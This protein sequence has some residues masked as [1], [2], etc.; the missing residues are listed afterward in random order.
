M[1][2][3]IYLLLTAIMLF[4]A[5]AAFGQSPP[6]STSSQ[7]VFQPASQQ[8]AMD[9]GLIGV[10]A[11]GVLGLLGFTVKSDRNDRHRLIDAITNLSK[12]Q[13]TLAAELRHG[14]QSMQNRIDTLHKDLQSLKDEVSRR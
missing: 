4:V 14:F 7:M 12:T 2:A 1:K 13:E 11:V 9:Y 6:Q 5:V 3:I 8:N 10:L